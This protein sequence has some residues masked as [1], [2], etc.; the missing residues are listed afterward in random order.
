MK[1]KPTGGKTFNCHNCYN[2]FFVRI[3]VCNAR[4]KAGVKTL[5]CC[6]KCR[7]ELQQK[8]KKSRKQICAD[9]RDS[10]KQKYSKMTESEARYLSKK[11]FGGM[12]EKVLDKYEHK[13][14]MCGNNLKLV[15]H[16]IDGKNGKNGGLSNNKLNNLIVLC[17]NCHPKVHN[18]HWLKEIK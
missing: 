16:H 5:C 7:R 9:Y 1:I 6:E 18:R 12:R 15:V 13:C 17:R 10:H 11:Y 3:G 2:N 14:A 8:N 4:E